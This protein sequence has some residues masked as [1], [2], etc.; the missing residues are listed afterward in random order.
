MA[1]SALRSRR[2]RLDVEDAANRASAY[3]YGNIVTLATLSTLSRDDA[4]S[5]KGFLVISG[6]AVSTYLAHAFANA[7]GRRMRATHTLHLRD[8][9]D[10]LR[11]SVP[12]LT[13]ALLPALL[14]LAAAAAHIPPVYAQVLGGAYLVIRL[15][16]VGVLVARLRGTTSSWR[17][18][19]AGI[20]LAVLGAV[21][22]LIKVLA[23]H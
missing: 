8:A 14:L 7:I 12:I 5:G 23:G 1:A 13:S 19:S 18:I 20:A 2:R 4:V 17:V 22:T 11:D 21:I 16:F 9:L 6:V 15:G 10:E 3:V